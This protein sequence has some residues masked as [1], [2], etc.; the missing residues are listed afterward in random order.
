M[1]VPEKAAR[2]GK[3]HP[4]P[5]L[6]SLFLLPVDLL[7]TQGLLLGRLLPPLKGGMHV[8]HNAST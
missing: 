1:T 6:R 8:L 3:N 5:S 7:V 2:G 4:S